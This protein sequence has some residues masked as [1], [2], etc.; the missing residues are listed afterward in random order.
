LGMAPPELLRPLEGQREETLRIVEGLSAQD[1]DRTVRGTG[2]TVRQCC[3]HLVSAELGEA[4]VIRRALDGEVMHLS[5]EDR[6]SFNEAQAD[7]AADWDLAR[8][9]TELAEALATLREVFEG[10]T[11]EDL[12]RAVRWPEW[13][14]RTIRTSIP[15]M[16]EHEDSHLD[17]IKAA[18]RD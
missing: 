8:I 7:G 17:E 12:D 1:L 13:P 18:T 15:Y 14:A 9:R 5:Q 2:W 16:V 10:M 3:A 4:F 6:D 11:E